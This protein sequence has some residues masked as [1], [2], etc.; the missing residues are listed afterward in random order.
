MVDFELKRIHTKGESQ[1]F[2]PKKNDQLE[3][4]LD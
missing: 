1:K 4:N 3:M 2:A